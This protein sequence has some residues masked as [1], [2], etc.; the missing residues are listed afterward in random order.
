MRPR[1]AFR[2]SIRACEIP[3]VL[4]GQLMNRCSQR[5]CWRRAPA[6]SVVVASARRTALERCDDLDECL[7][8]AGSRGDHDRPQPRR[9]SSSIEAPAADATISR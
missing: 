6:R 9:L 1:I 2:P 4:E 5:N 3:I 8:P 7:V